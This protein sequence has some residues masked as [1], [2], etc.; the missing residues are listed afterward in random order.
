MIRNR[1]TVQPGLFLQAFIVAQ[2]TSSVIE[3]VVEGSAVT[4]SEFALTSWLNVIGGATPTEAA[5]QLGLSP[6]TL[7]AMIDRLVRKGQLRRTRHPEDG[8]S[9]IL[10]LTAKGKATNARNGERF[11][12]RLAELQANLDGEPEAILAAMRRLEDGLRATLAPEK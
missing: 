5:L 8:R 2:L 11:V 3:T 10:E 7:S 6:T 4:A 9:Y 1:T 12:R